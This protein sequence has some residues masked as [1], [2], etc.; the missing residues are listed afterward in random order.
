MTPGVPTTLAQVDAVWLSEVF[1]LPIES[2]D[3]TQL[4]VGSA[5][6]GTV[7]RLQM[8]APHSPNVPATAIVK[9][10]A[11]DPAALAVGKLLKVW[12]REAMFYEQ[13]APRLPSTISVPRSYRTIIEPSSHRAAVLIEDMAPAAAGDQVKGAS[14]EAARAA[15]AALAGLHAPW[16]GMPRTAHLEWVPGIDRPNTGAG[17]QGA[18]EASFERFAA[19]FAYLLEAETI[20]WTRRF[21][22]Q[23]RDYLASMARRPL[24]IAHADF[25]LENMLFAP[26]DD[27]KV[28]IVDWQT[29][30]YTGGATDLSFFCTTSLDITT[31]RAMEDELCDLY[32]DT[33]LQLGVEPSQTAHVRDDYRSSMLW[34]M[35]MLANNLADMATP[36]RRSVDLFEAMLTRLHT[37]ALDHE[38]GDLV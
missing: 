3:V 35:A 31:R 36:D 2:V 28:T 30:M 21:V 19:R 15:V 10:P 22:P 9:L 8:S 27:S 6:L 4:A 38:L 32:I 29:A 20:E 16:W 24:T 26:G 18:M 17:L 5:F 1:G 33:L 14:P 13:L 34:W 12:H 37:A 11:T 7:G 25:R 23:V